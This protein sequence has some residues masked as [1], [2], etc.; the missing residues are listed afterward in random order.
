MEAVINAIAH[1][2]YTIKNTF[3]SLYIYF[4]RI[5][6]TSPEKLFPP[7][8]LKKLGHCLPAH[9]N[10]TL[11]DVLSQTKFMEHVGTGIKRMNDAMAS[12]GLS[13]PIYEEDETTFKVVFKKASN[14]DE[15]NNF[16]SENIQNL[17][18]Y[19]LNKR[20]IKALSLIINNKEVMTV[21]RYSNLFNISRPSASRDLN[22]LLET[23]LINKIKN[24]KEFLY[25]AKDLD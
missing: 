12:N 18:S 11:C 20:Q 16:P 17:D 6:I 23:N 25:I 24:S 21:N 10:K 7:V 15:I 8:T 9:R 5:E 3:I 22:Q 13:K 4:D 2:N 19:N 14:I 1:R